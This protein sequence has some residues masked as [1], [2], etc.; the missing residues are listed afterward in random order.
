VAATL[1]RVWENVF[2]WEHLPWLHRGSFSSIELADSGTWGWRAE[3]GLQPA[4][5]P[6][7][8]LELVREPDEERYVSRTLAGPGAGSEIWTRL[9]PHGERTD[10]EVEFH[11]PGIAPERA[12]AM[13]E[14]F[15]GLYTRLWDEDEGM[16]VERSAQLA[17][18]VGATRTAPEPTTLSLGPLAELRAGLPRSVDWG[19]VR[20]RIVALGEGLA[21]HACVCPHRLGPLDDAEVANGRI[22][23]PWH[24]YE[25]DLR[26]GRSSDG[27]GLRLAPAPR[28]EIDP[29]TTEVR[30]TPQRGRS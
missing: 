20:Y 10:V 6:P 14:L 28:L 12:D 3:I 1:E 17:R 29:T 27:R 24:G 18:R 4:G 8:L 11:L 15:V 16:M 2:D 19:G 26:T 25:F 9:T 21:V 13:G 22:R 7:I 30:L 5:S 23:C